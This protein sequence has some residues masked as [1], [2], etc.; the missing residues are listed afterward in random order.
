M[1]P[2]FFITLAYSSALNQVV[3]MVRR[4]KKEKMVPTAD[5]I[6]LSH[7]AR[8]LVWKDASHRGLSSIR[9]GGTTK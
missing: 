7:P 3:R 1:G 6:G 8:A 5:L 2:D 9:P 4:N